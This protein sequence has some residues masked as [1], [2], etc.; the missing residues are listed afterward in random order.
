MS[1]YTIKSV[2]DPKPWS[3]DY[4]SFLSYP[5]D[6][7]DETGK[8]HLGVEWSR[9]AESQAPQVEDRIAGT[10]EAGKFGDKLK[11]DF[12]ATKELK[13]GTGSS[14]GSGNGGGGFRGGGKSADVEASIHRQVALKILAPT[15][16]DEGLSDGVK[17]TVREIETFIAASGAGAGVSPGANDGAANATPASPQ[18]DGTH[19]RL[20][21]LLEAGGVNS[22]ASTLITNW[23]LSDGLTEAE[24]DAALAALLDD[25]K[26]PRA[27]ERL[28][29]RYVQ[30]NGELPQAAALDDLSDIPFRR[31]EYPEAFS[32]RLRWRR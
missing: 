22:A 32:E 15:I 29:E 30:A 25:A 3:N 17:A 21:E 5:V 7:E 28:Q 31:P 26:R 11:V 4:G 12:E 2:G 8:K 27:V 19:Q 9:K 23:A 10:I 14:G 1:S 6:L 24:Q 20:T 18:N 13:G 16:N